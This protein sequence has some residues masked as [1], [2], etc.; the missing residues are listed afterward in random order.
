VC[1]AQKSTVV[2]RIAA[3]LLVHS[4]FVIYPST[5]ML[6]AQHYK[7]HQRDMARSNLND[8]THWLATAHA[9]ADASGAVITPFFRKRLRIDNKA[10]AGA[11]DPVTAA[12]KASER[13]IR[14]IIRHEFPEHGIVG[15]EY[16]DLAGSSPFRWV[17]DPI[18]GT[19]AF[20]MGMPLWGT[21]IGLLHRDTPIVGMMDQPYTRERFW[22]TNKGAYARSVTGEIRR[23]KTRS[24][25]ALGDAILT[26]T[27]PDLFKAGKEKQAFGQLAHEVRMTRY[28]GDCYAYCMLAA[29]HID[30]V[31][32]AGLK[33]FDI[34]PLI[35]VIE[36]A[37]GVVT[38]WDGSP[39][40]S[41][42]RV[43]AA[44]DPVL[45]AKAVK[46]LAI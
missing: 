6:P 26:S 17:I 7:R 42:G 13:A 24:C 38:A 5:A 14:K 22:G 2:F 1:A 18:D 4:Y 29:G 36:A 30:L 15:E 3:C 31:V 39:A 40:T 9:L 25:P 41:G 10:E 16:A 20:M 34:V 43:I 19:R 45:H 11:F 28:G 46:R 32:E 44:G 21:L 35:P 27:S 8:V 37:G 33:V 23:M 12:D